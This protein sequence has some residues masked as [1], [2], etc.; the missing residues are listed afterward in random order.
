ML[1]HKTRNFKCHNAVSLNNLMPED[2]FYRIVEQCI[3]PSFV[4]D[5]VSDFYSDMGRH[6]S[7]LKSSSNSN[8]SHSLKAS[9]LK[10]S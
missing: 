9:D 8:S 10:D 3:D 1:G 7:I 6:P 4:R 2:K 5:L